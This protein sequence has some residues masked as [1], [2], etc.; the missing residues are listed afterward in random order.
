MALKVYVSYAWKAEEDSGVVAALET[1]L[2]GQ[3][4]ELVRDVR[5]VGYGES[6]RAFM[7]EIGAADQ[8][9]L[10]LSEAY[11]RSPYCLYE[12]RAVAEHRD[13]RRRV[14]PIVLAGCDLHDPLWWVTIVRY[15]EGKVGELKVALTE[16]DRLNIGPLNQRLDEY[17]DFRRLVAGHM[18]TLADMNALTEKVHR[19]TDFAALVARLQSCSEAA[20]LPKPAVQHPEPSQ[21]VLPLVVELP[22]LD[23]P[24]PCWAEKVEHD[25]RGAFISVDWLGVRHRLEWDARSKLWWGTKDVGVDQNGLFG[26]ADLGG[27]RQRFRWIPPGEFWMGSPAEEEGRFASEG[28]R[29]RVRLTEGFWLA[30]TACSQSVWQAVVGNNPSYFRGDPQN[31]VERV[32]WDDVQGFLR[33]VEKRLPGVKANLP[34]EAEWEYA[35]RAGSETA[36]SW[37]DGIA[38]EQANYDARA[39]YAQGPT[40]DWRQKTLPVKSY[41]PNAWGLY[42]MHGNVWEWC[43]DGWREYDGAPQVDPRGAEGGEAWASRAIRGGAWLCDPQW[44]RVAHQDGRS[45]RVCLRVLGFRFSLKST[46]VEGEDKRLPETVTTRDV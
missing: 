24:T 20:A 31:P 41:A 25:G 19:V 32:S 3:G 9:V 17:A 26:Y 22:T 14:H 37:G 38:P 18:A 30:D 13:F 2:A 15:W 16:I 33:E 7:D 39:S 1:A 6:I 23:V 12:L 27:V 46:G 40:G 43:A 34:T 11:F 42:Q 36:F 35:C 44:L 10:V 29:H 5:R 21:P 8:V 28:P 4:V 45:R